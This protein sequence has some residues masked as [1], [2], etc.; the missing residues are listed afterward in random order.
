[1][2]Q[3]LKDEQ[4][5][6]AINALQAI[7]D[8]ILNLQAMNDQFNERKNDNKISQSRDNV[9]DLLINID[10]SFFTDWNKEHW[11]YLKKKTSVIL[12][13]LIISILKY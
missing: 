9:L 4:F 8:I 13:K 11:Y 1:M 3:S 2:A 7:K 5:N 6:E 10:V 12:F